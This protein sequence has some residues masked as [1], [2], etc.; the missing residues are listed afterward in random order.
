VYNHIPNNL[1]VLAL[2]E[3]WTTEARDKILSKTKNTYKYHYWPQEYNENV[4]CDFS[5]PSVHG[6]SFLYW[7]CLVRE[8]V[9]T[10]QLQQP[11]SAIPY[12]CFTYA[13]TLAL[14]D[15]SKTWE[16]Q[17]CLACLING[18]EYLPREQSGY[19][20]EM[21][22]SQQGPKYGHKG[23]NGQLILSKHPIQNVVE[24]RFPAFI[25]NRVNI[26]ATIAGVKFGFG[27]FAF[28]L[29]EDID[30]DYT[31]AM[32]GATQP[33]HAQDF[34][35]AGVDV[36]VGDLNTGPNYQSLGF[37]T[38]LNNGYRLVSPNV[39]TWC[40]KDHAGFLPCLNALSIP[41]PIDHILVRK[42][43]AIFS[44]HATTFNN[45]PIMSDHI[46]VSTW[47]FCWWCI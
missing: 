45:R 33:A 40:D 2:Q 23:V 17:L 37:N 20:F 38:L 5:D 14:F 7:D 31:G 4:G 22:G 9:D 10:Q 44:F 46:G 6:L 39:P 28:N 18:M 42:K 32:Y 12:E 26:H 47:L 21:C 27:H 19:I 8:G 13:A 25:V 36:I 3:V 30:T 11:L 1:D 34:I 16:N 15:L 43:S 29:L 35:D 24:H 41:M